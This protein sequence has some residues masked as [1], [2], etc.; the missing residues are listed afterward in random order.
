MPSRK[1]QRVV[2]QPTTYMGMQEGIN[3]IISAVRPTLG[4]RP[5]FTANELKRG[6]DTILPELLDDG[7]VIARRII[8]LQDRNNDVGAMFI[9]NVLWR[10]HEDAGDGTATAAVLFQSIYDRS[11]RYIVAGGNAMRMRGYFEHGLR[12]ILDELDKMTYKIEGG[13]EQLARVA[14]SVCY[15]EQLAKLL[16]EIFDIIGEYGRLEI[17]S[18]HGREHRREYVEGSYWAGGILSRHLINDPARLRGQLD[19][20]RILISDLKIEDPY[21][22]AHVIEVARTAEIQNLVI[23]AEKLSDSVLATLL[24]TQQDSEGIRIIAVKTPQSPADNV[25]TGLEDLAVLTGGRPF[26]SIAGDTLNKV[27]VEDFGL[28]RRAWADR[29]NFGIVAGKGDPHILREHIATLRTAYNNTQDLK[30]REEL[31]KR[32]GKLMGGSATLWIGGSTEPEVEEGK[33]LARRGSFTMRGAVRDGVLPGG[34]S[35]LMACRPAVRRLRDES[36]DLDARAAYGILLSSLPEP[37]RTIM[38]N[39]GYDSAEYMADIRRGETGTGFDALNGQVVDM[40]EAGILDVATTVKAAVRA[41]I[42]SAA[43]ALTVDILVHP[44]HQRVTPVPK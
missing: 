24:S 19:N 36:Q 8:Q 4:P 43:L 30:I 34:G 7:G 11:V 40:N 1:T 10:L 3:Q 2:F 5:R 28:A 33:E 18:G 23:M 26:I 6:G 29:R 38:T 41:A 15:D 32:I 13:K 21:E 9:R 12:V 20:P 39:A 35:A 22:I 17:R 27:K 44:K 37:M 31:Q 16:G 14:Q 25:Q 42:S